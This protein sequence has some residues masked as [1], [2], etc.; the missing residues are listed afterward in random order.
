MNR[1]KI[2][3]G[4]KHVECLNKKKCK[5]ERKMKKKAAQILTAIALM[6]TASASMGCFIWC[7]EEPKALKN[8]D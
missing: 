6:L 1:I 7:A 8:M 5:G 2:I 4:F 3:N